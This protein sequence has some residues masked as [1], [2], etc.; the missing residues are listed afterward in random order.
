MKILIVH[1]SSKI[2]GSEKSMLDF[3]CGLKKQLLNKYQI[4]IACPKG[5]ILGGKVEQLGYNVIYLPFFKYKKKY[6]SFIVSI[7]Q[8]TLLTCKLIFII[9]RYQIIHANSTQAYI[10]SILATILLNKPI[11]WHVRDSINTLPFQIFFERMASI[12][13]PIS[14]FVQHTLKNSS[15]EKVK[16]IYNGVIVPKKK[17]DSIIDLDFYL[18]NISQYVKW[19]K[20]EIL[21]EA[22]RLLH[23]EFPDLKLICLGSS[24]DRQSAN[25]LIE[26]KNKVNMYK[27]SNHII[28]QG[29]TKNIYQYIINC[30]CL[31]HPASDEPL[32]R[33]VI[34]AMGL[35]K[36]VIA[37]KSGGITEYVKNGING[38]LFENCN[39]NDLIHKIRLVL[40][41]KNKEKIQINARN[42][43]KKI[44][45][46]DDYTKKILELYDTVINI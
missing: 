35:N 16:Q 13:I 38:F 37:S 4:D 34:E 22:M 26:L 1:H 29:F 27:L 17:N 11:I 6:L 46:I 39:L 12:I 3:L 23:N 28:F 19:K 9:K 7:F 14:K 8:Q 18:L 30:Q 45:N 44:F 2:S 20:H 25:Y 24:I 5:D 40:S 31:V 21:I 41:Y 33:A 32:G 15:D 42:T 36:M 10:Q 43:I